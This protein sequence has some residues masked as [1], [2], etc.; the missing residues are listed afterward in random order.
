M[1]RS[2]KTLAIERAGKENPCLTRSAIAEHFGVSREYVRT[3][4]K[5]ARINTRHIIIK[6]S[7]LCRCGNEVTEKGAQYCYDCR[8]IR[9]IC[10]QCGCVYTKH[11][12]DVA[13]KTMKHRH[14]FCSKQ[15]QGR[16]LGERYGRFS[17]GDTSRKGK[18][19]YD[20]IL[21]EIAHRLVSG[22]SMYHIGIAM[23]IP[24]GSIGMIADKILRLSS[25]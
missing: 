23:G 16:W 24:V 19:K 21:P 25:V 22:E 14:Q 7:R 13:N 18:S 10:D 1:I 4:L 5:R 17:L 11:I 15:C 2:A 3:V 20:Y 6:S 12:K 8:H 9:L